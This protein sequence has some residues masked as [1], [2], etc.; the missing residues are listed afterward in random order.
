[1]GESHFRVKIKADAFRG[2][3]RVQQHRQVNAVLALELK[4]RVHA[5]A[6]EASV[7]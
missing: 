1:M 5:L 4:N 7:P 6:I 2:L 3:S